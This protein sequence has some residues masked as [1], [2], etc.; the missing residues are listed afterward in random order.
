MIFLRAALFSESEGDWP[1]L[2]EPR[3]LRG[4]ALVLRCLLGDVAASPLLPDDGDRK[5]ELG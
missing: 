3:S 2:G 5:D 4:E 1:A